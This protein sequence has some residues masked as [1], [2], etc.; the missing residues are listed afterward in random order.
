MPR[1]RAASAVFFF[2]L[3]RIAGGSDFDLGEVGIEPQ[4]VPAGLL[5][6]LCC[7]DESSGTIVHGFAQSSE[8]A[9]GFRSEKDEGLLRF[10]W[11][12]DKDAFFAHRLGPGFDSLE[13]IRR[14]RVGG[15][16]QEGNNQDVVGGLGL[17]QVWMN[18]ETVIGQEVGNLSD[19]QSFAV[20]LHMDVYFRADEIKGRRVS[21]SSQRHGGREDDDRHR[22]QLPNRR[23]GQQ[24]PTATWTFEPVRVDCHFERDWKMVQMHHLS[25]VRMP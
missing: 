4:A 17:G 3:F 12:D 11:H 6:I 9:D 20:P 2:Q 14:R 19:G 21:E 8:I 25:I 13:P 5:K 1:L 24:R 7:P 18:P 16:P 23:N 22:Q 10:G 15:S